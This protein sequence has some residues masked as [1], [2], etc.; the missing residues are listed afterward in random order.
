MLKKSF[1]A[2]ALASSLGL[3]G[4]GDRAPHIIQVP[5][6]NP[7][8][9]E[10]PGVMTVN[11]QATLEVSPDCADLTITISSDNAVPGSS[12]KAL[13]RKK[14]ALIAA[15]QKI[16]VESGQVKLSNLNLDPIYAPNPEGWATL[17]VRTYRSSITL[18]ATTKDFSKLGDMMNA[19][20]GA[21]ATYM[22]AAFR[23][24]DLPELKKKVRD[25]AL[26]AAK[27][28]AQQTA[29]TLG[30]K[31]GRI[32]SVG[33]NMGGYMWSNTYFPSNAAAIQDTSNVVVLGGQLQPLTLDVN[34]TFE[35]A[36]S[37]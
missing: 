34:I 17:K 9:I 33:E 28:K 27:E 15:L 3:T 30:I 5:S 10:R 32:T 14:L 29:A 20:A 2:L 35:L 13:E 22:N 12:V 31:L 11:G 21:G 37:A 6:T 23:R 36:K 18:T 25:M 26:A 24:S 4:C 8:E 19:A 7:G 1:V 16:G